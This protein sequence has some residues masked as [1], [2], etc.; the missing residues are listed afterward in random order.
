MDARYQKLADL[1]THYSLKLKR[2]EVVFIDAT[3]V[4]EG[5]CVEM[6]RAVRRAGATPLIEMRQSRITREI[7]LGSDETHAKLVRDIEMFRMKKVD[8][9]VA[10]YERM[11][12]SAG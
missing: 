11:I 2:G 1:L 6:L 8:A 3:D 5:F 7:L 9:Y 12:S 10:L 4:P